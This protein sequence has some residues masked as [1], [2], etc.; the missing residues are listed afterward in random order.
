M[1][2]QPLYPHKCSTGTCV[3]LGS[4][5]PGGYIYPHT[6]DLYVCILHNRVVYAR[7][8]DVHFISGMQNDHFPTGDPRYEALQRA[9]EKRYIKE[10]THERFSRKFQSSSHR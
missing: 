2:D 3:Y 4:Y 8:S 7:W 9:K 6:Y 5:T 1:S 10:N